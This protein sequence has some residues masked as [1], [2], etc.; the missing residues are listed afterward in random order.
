M[1]ISWDSIRSLLLFFGPV[2]LPKAISWYRSVRDASRDANLPLCPAPPHARRAIGLLAGLAAVFLVRALLPVFAPENLF[3]ATQ[4]RLQIPVDVLFARVAAALRH[5]G[6]SSSSSGGGGGGGGTM[7]LLSPSDEALR[8]RFVNLESRLLY[9]QF[10]PDVL[11]D[12]PF[13]TADEPRTYFYYALPALLAPHLAN[14]V[15]LAVVTSPSLTGKPG[16]QWRRLAVVTAS[17]VAALDVYLVSSYNYQ[18]NARA[19]RLSDV[20]FFFWRARA[21]RLVA[22]AA[23]DALLAALLYLSATNRAFA[24]LPSPAERVDA[25]ARAVAAAK[26]RMSAVGIIKNT[27]LRD[28]DLRA[29]SHAYWTHE[30]RLMRDVMEERD[31]IEGVNDALA[32]RID[33]QAISR[34][35]DMYAHSVLEQL[36]QDSADGTI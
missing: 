29:R 12:C 4:S 16:A 6:S 19:L 2:L 33:I 1:A 31:V 32:N 14:L 26:S 18:A 5:R 11:A 27:A 8:A 24:Q 21:G 23:L 7:S 13:C 9:L 36:R 34:D 20:D 17:V 30:V 28:E 3:A 22:L 25:A 15:A 35:A 10:G